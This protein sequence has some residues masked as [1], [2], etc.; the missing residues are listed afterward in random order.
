MMMIVAVAGKARV[1]QDIVNL[2]SNKHTTSVVC[3]IHRTSCDNILF[4][5]FLQ[6]SFH[7][8]SCNLQV[9]GTLTMS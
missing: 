4:D 5:L 2:T 9:I 8:L 6:V 7:V 1:I 3:G